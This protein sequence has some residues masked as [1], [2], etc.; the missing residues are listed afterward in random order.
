[1]KN[2]PN[3]FKKKNS[4][5]RRVSS[6]TIL[7]LTNDGI[8]IFKKKIDYSTIIKK[9]NLNKNKSI[10]TSNALSASNRFLLQKKEINKKKNFSHLK[11]IFNIN[12]KYNLYLN[13]SS[14]S[15]LFQIE[16]NLKKDEKMPLIKNYINNSKEEMLNTSY[17]HIFQSSY[18]SKMNYKNKIN[19]RK[20]FLVK[21][22]N[23]ADKTIVIEDEPK[24]NIYNLKGKYKNII[25]DEVKNLFKQKENNTWRVSKNINSFYTMKNKKKVILNKKAN[26]KIINKQKSENN[27]LPNQNINNNKDKNS[28]IIIKNLKKKVSI[29]GLNLPITK[30]DINNK[31]IDKNENNEQKIKNSIKNTKIINNKNEKIEEAK[32]ESIKL[33]NGNTKNEKIEIKNNYINNKDLYKNEKSEAKTKEKK[34]ISKFLINNE[35]NNSKKENYSNNNS[36]NSYNGKK[37]KI[38][39]N[40]I[41]SLSSMKSSSNKDRVVIISEKDSS[42]S[43]NS[44]FSKINKK[45]NEYDIDLDDNKNKLENNDK[46]EISHLYSNKTLVDSLIPNKE[47]NKS[48]TNN[49][50]INQDSFLYSSKSLR[51]FLN[52]SKDEKD[53]IF[54]FDKS[55]DKIDD[56]KSDD[57]KDDKSNEGNVDKSDVKKEKNFIRKRKVCFSSAKIFQF[58]F[59]KNKE[60]VSKMSSKILSDESGKNSEESSKKEKS[61]ERASLKKINKKVTINLTKKLLVVNTKKKLKRLKTFIKDHKSSLKIPT[62]YNGLNS[63]KVNFINKIKNKMDKNKLNKNTYSILKEKVRLLKSTIDDIKSD[64]TNQEPINILNKNIDEEVIKIFIDGLFEFDKDYDEFDFNYILRIPCNISYV[65]CYYIFRNIEFRGILRNN[66]DLEY[67]FGKYDNIMK[68]RTRKSVISL[69]NNS[70]YIIPNLDRFIIDKTFIMDTDDDEEWKREKYNFMTIHRFIFRSLSWAKNECS[71][72]KSINPKKFELFQRN[73]YKYNIRNT[74]HITKRK[75]IGIKT[76]VNSII[77]TNIKENDRGNLRKKTI[78]LYNRPN[79]DFRSSIKKRKNKNIFNISILKRKQFFYR[80]N[81]I[82]NA[83]NPHRDSK[84]TLALFDDKDNEDLTLNNHNEINST[85][86]LEHAKKIDDVYFGL[87]LLIVEGKEY[88]FRKYFTKYEKTIDINFPIYEGNTLLIMSTKEGMPGITRFLCEKKADVNVKNDEGNTA[89]HYAIGQKFYK[90]VD[91]LTIFGAREDILNNKGYSPWELQ[92]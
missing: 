27:L 67:I 85:N 38:E 72:I 75:I 43:F 48:P 20:L 39:K 1:M 53:D 30:K 12:Q 90:L 64:F 14:Y 77:D 63:Q 41:K 16:N 35:E 13:N 83:N 29:N 26:N 49:N 5:L 76:L 86:I 87:S 33:I 32:K 71:L 92:P 68:K 74:L 24:I 46:H 6:E 65:L 8:S 4:S 55:D 54:Q 84:D 25:S 51:Y 34:I 22:D 3:I 81:D 7:P 28:Y 17:S 89:L 88:L 52:D 73:T 50:E 23:N 45:G 69:L 2:I 44:D 78:S 42:N 66:Y 40:S 80:K 36:N 62:K 21:K 19:L 79:L 10:D 82:Y 56:D 11:S 58:K 57:K 47:E 31:S 91:I 9:K 15:T 18:R 70:D 37:D 59:D 60:L 61:L